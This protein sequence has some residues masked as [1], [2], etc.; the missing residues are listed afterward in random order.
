MTHRGCLIAH[1]GRVIAHGGCI[2]GY[3]GCVIPHGGCIIAHRGCIIEHRGC[4]LAHKGLHYTIHGLHY[5]AQRLHYT[6]HGLQQPYQSTPL[7]K[8]DHG[9][10]NITTKHCMHSKIQWSRNAEFPTRLY[11][12]YACSQ[13]TMKSGG[14][15]WAVFVCSPP[16]WVHRA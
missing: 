8:T 1:R 10:D 15:R 12:L 2:I 3:R 11:S 4:I 9:C 13:L 6:Q 5:T 16:A 7:N 14:C